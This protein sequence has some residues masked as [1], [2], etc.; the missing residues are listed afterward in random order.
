MG[1]LEIILLIAGAIILILG[2]VLPAKQ[3][4]KG[5]GTEKIAE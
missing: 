3:E 5:A 2:Y 1:A 4:D